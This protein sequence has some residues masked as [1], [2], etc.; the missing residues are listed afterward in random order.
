[1]TAKI[2]NSYDCNFNNKDTKTIPMMAIDIALVSLLSTLNIIV[3]VSI[4]HAVL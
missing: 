2:P 3:L 4:L 1:M